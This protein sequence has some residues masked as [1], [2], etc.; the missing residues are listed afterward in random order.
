M[1]SLIFFFDIA[2][3]LRFSRYHRC[4]LLADRAVSKLCL[5]TVFKLQ[6]ITD[7]CIV[8]VCLFTTVSQRS[9]ALSQLVR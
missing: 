2:T 7:D 1:I 6:T 9:L 8:P 3:I 5:A 4:P